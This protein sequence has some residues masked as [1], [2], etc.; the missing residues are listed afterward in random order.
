METDWATHLAKDGPIWTILGTFCIAIGF[1]TKELIKAYTK[2]IDDTKPMITAMNSI[3][4]TNIVLSSSI[5]DANKL[6]S[7]Q[8]KSMVAQTVVIES[9]NTV[10]KQVL[11]EI[12]RLHV[13]LDERTVRIEGLLQDRLD[14]LEAGQRELAGRIPN[15]RPT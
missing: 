3:S 13:R 15:K 8:N 9:L 7:D 11:I 14:R 12:E 2:S 5:T 1:L 6:Q 4:T 10:V